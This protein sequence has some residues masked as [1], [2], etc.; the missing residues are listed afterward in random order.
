MKNIFKSKE[1]FA[2]TSILYSIFLL[3]LLFIVLIFLSI[4]NNYLTLSKMQK[5][6]KE[7]L[8]EVSYPQ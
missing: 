3:A 8:D 7:N 5:A 2:I 1:G 6:V 4:T